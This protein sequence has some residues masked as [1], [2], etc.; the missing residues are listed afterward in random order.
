MNSNKGGRPTKGVASLTFLKAMLKKEA[1]GEW[2]QEI[3][4]RNRGRAYRVPAEGVVPR[5]PQGLQG[6]PKDQASRFFQLASGHAMIAPFLKEKFGWV[7][8]DSCWRCGCGI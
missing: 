4:E 6:A 5:I 1:V 3:L 2:R 8:S 7:E